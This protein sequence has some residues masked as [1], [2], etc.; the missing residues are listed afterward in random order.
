MYIRINSASY[1]AVSSVSKRKSNLDTLY[2]PEKLYEHKAHGGMLILFHAF[3]KVIKK[4]IKEFPLE[5]Q[6]KLG[7]VSQTELKF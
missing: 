5:V 6:D 4:F 3:P 1:S 7:V 2:R